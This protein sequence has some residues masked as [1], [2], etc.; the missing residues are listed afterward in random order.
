LSAQHRR[1]RSTLPVAAAGRSLLPRIARRPDILTLTRPQ[2]NT[3]TRADSDHAYVTAAQIDQTVPIV[4]V[5]RAFDRVWAGE[6]V[7]VNVPS[8]GGRSSFI[9]A[10]LGTLPEVEILPAGDGQPARAR[11]APSTTPAARTPP[12]GYDELILALRPLSPA[13]PALRDRP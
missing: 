11:L 5:Q 12:R 2:P 3:I 8:L 10:V 9:G 13:R 6:E 1:R 4:T 7:A